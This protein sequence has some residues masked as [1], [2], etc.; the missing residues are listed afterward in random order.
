MATIM[1]VDMDAF[2]AAV[3]ILD[4][5]EYKGKPLIIG[6]YKD[7]RRGVVSTCSYEARKYGIHSAMPIVK[8]AA[9]CPH[10]VFIP[11]RM[12]RYQE[13][14]RQIHAIFPEFSPVV[15]PLSIDEAF[16]DMTGCEHFYDSLEAM[17]MSLKKRIKETTG[18]TASVGI[19][20]NKFL[21]KL[22][23]D[24]EKP[25]GLT[26]IRPDEISTILNPLPVG[27]LWGVGKK[28]EQELNRIG[29]YKIG[30]LLAYSL[31]ELEEK[32]GSSFGP[33]LYYL[34]R[35]I[36]NR[37]VEP[38][39]EA[40]SIGH[41]ITFD[42]DQ[43]SFALI[44]GQLG[45]LVEDVGWRLRQHGLY[46][47]TVTLKIRYYDFKTITRSHTHETSFCDDDTIFQTAVSLLEKERLRPVRLIGVTVSN[48]T[49]TAQLSLFDE[50]ENARKL[51]AVMDTINA[52]FKRGAIT[53]GRT[54][55]DEQTQ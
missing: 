42:E 12:K 24:L 53:K 9:L 17:G 37:K 28:A 11:G 47:R 3:E 55:I 45:R 20:P 6:G 31:P 29:I 27:K 23:S 21:A 34:A 25:D 44:R 19:A 51:S 48:L 40:K 33:H 50:T 49:E 4:N 14:S 8:A 54:L 26:V 32:F 41:E 15:E 16:L 13:V 39:H 1:H 2:F 36:D 35:G 18:L 22:A 10:G 5:P 52:R 46:A 7:S 38:I 43:T 30:D